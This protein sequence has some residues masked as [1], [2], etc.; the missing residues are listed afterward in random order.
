M[1]G[2]LKNQRKLLNFFRQK[3]VLSVYKA[4]EPLI[5]WYPQ[6]YKYGTLSS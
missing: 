3:I 4:T 1:D 5:C 6:N 2:H